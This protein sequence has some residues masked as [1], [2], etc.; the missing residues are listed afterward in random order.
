MKIEWREVELPDFGVPEIPPA[1]P[2]EVYEERCRKAYANAGCDWLVI[3][4]DREHF[5]NL[6]YLTAFDPRFEEAVLLLGP[7]DRRILIVGNEGLGYTSRAGLKLDFALCQTFSLM[8][9]DRSIAPRLFDVLIQA[10][11]R[12]GQRLGLVGWKYLEPE[13]WNGGRQSYFA[14]AILVDLLREITGDPEA[15]VDSTRVLMHPAR[16]LRSNN[17]VE[18]IAAFEW[19]AAR[20]S[21]AVMRIVRSAQPGMTELQAVAWMGFSGEPLSAHVMFA[22]GKN[23]IIG[24]CSPTARRI[25]RG[26]GASTAVGFWGGL[27]CRAGLV[28]EEQDEFLNRIAI[29]YFRGLAAWYNIVHIGIKGSEVF[30][31]VS[32]M[33]ARAGLRSALNPGH[34]TS[35]DEWVHS[36]IRPG[37]AEQISSGMAFQSDI[38]PVPIPP[39]YAINCEDTLVFADGNLRG[40]LA[41]RYPEAWSRIQARQ[42]FMRQKLGIE[43][44]DEVLPLSTMPAYLPPLWLSPSRVLVV[45]EI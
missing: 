6:T 15:V 32:E 10:G 34:L 22:S 25:E 39:G 40:E 20:A 11:I 3:Y 21:S 44:S 7:E 38:I 8:G 33:L 28:M 29:P 18:Q 31:T 45:D 36:P 23:E 43:I 41:R 16:G 30:E 42:D 17:E 12:P 13:E 26:D 1:I 4:G 27:C 24:L 14:P 37:S 35:L 2:A 5:A 19:A 9:Q